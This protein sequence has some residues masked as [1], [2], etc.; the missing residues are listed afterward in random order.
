MPEL[1]KTFPCNCNKPRPWNQTTPG[2]PTYDPRLT[3]FRDDYAGDDQF[4][5][6]I[7]L[8]GEQ[9]VSGDVF[10]TVY[11]AYDPPGDPFGSCA[12][13]DFCNSSAVDPISNACVHVG[14]PYRSVHQ[15][16]G[17]ALVE[18]YPYFGMTRGSVSTLLPSLYSP[19]LNNSRD[20][21]VYV[22]ASLRQNPTSRAVNVMIVNDGTPYYVERLAFAGGMDNAVLTGAVPETIMIGLPQNGE[23]GCERQFELTFSATA[24]GA[25]CNCNSG[26]S[27]CPSGGT[28][29]YLA[30]IRDTVVPAVT[31]ALN[32]TAGEISMV[33][34]SYG[35]LTACYAAATHPEYYRRVYCQ[36]P[37]VWWNYGELARVVATNAAAATHHRPLAVVVY[38][39]TTEMEAP[40][41]TS[42]YGNF[43]IVLDHF[44][45]IFQLHTTPHAR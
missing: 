28:E 35:G 5:K 2:A 37:S 43:D 9:A 16:T 17:T 27:T 13:K 36:S 40:L 1:K 41:C 21:P 10:V 22:P 11:A 12:V 15:G 39:G 29:A 31:E 23:T 42:V 7:E 14:M 30:Y 20:I 6:Q 18:A 3:I 25:P 4:V 45:R 34:V 32:V 38:I 8:T 44:S 33:G 19:Q 26:D 24:A